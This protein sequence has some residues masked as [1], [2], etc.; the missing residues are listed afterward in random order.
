MTRKVKVSLIIL[1]YNGIDLTLDVLGCISS[2][3]VGDIDIE[4]VVVDNASKDETPERLKNYK[5]PNM[6]F[7]LITNSTNLGFAGGNNVGIKDALKRGADF[8]I[9]L[10]NDIYFPKN[11]VKILVSEAIKDKEI[12]L[13]S[14]KMYFAEGYE[15]HKD[16]YK[17]K[18]LG[19]VFWYA[20]GIIDKK[21]VYSSHRGVDEVDNGQFDKQEKTDYANGAFVL[22]RSQVFRDIG[23][24]D[25][26][27]FLY[28]EDADFSQRAKNKGWKVIYCPKTY[29]WHKVSVAAGGPGGETNDYFLTRNRLI[30]G[31][32]YTPLRTQI[33]LIRDSIRLLFKGRYW[34]KK[35]VVDFYLK[36]WG[37]GTRIK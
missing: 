5:L 2:L 9:L 7:K 1:A 23:F 37:K 35:G 28:W 32:R 36:R 8:V 34:Q 26:K 33:A 11:I 6:P 18:E 15:F 30:Y 27:L 16:R 21:N 13:I 3:D 20:G 19:K 12:G 10:N 25:E 4:T 29:L 17:Q 31:F 14:P 24:L 22:V